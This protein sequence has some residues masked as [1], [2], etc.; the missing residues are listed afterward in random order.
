[1]F[2]KRQIHPRFTQHEPKELISLC[3][4]TAN[5]ARCPHSAPE[6]AASSCSTAAAPRMEWHA[7]T[8]RL[9]QL[10][11]VGRQ[12]SSSPGRILICSSCPVTTMLDAGVDL[13]DVQI[14]ARHGDPHTVICYGQRPRALIKLRKNL[15]GEVEGNMQSFS[16]DYIWRCSR[17]VSV[18]EYCRHR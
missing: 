15:T 6:Y 17:R 12:A 18:L 11:A 3:M 16:Q 2:A 1:M 9:H 8:R 10:A 4:H 7:A 5:R 13:R 14:D